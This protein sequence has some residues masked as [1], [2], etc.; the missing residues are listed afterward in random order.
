MTANKSTP[1]KIK[2]YGIPASLLA[3]GIAVGSM[4]VPINLASAQDDAPSTEGEASESSDGHHRGRHAK[5][6][7]LQE[8]LGLDREGFKAAFDEGKTLVEIAAE[9]GLS[10]DELV[11]ALVASAEERIDAAVEAGKLDPAEA[12]EKAAGVE[13]RIS[14]K[15]NADPSELRRPGHRARLA[16][17][18]L[19][20][21]GLD[22]DEVKTG[23]E[24]GKTLAAIAAEQGVSEDQLV[25]A[26]VEAAEERIDA[27]VE[28]DKIDAAEAA[29]KK[30]D[31]AENIME[32]VNAD[33]ADR[34]Q[35]GEGRPGGHHRHGG[36][37]G[38]VEDSATS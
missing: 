19:E 16:I 26:L 18:V 28:E 27:A 38:D 5:A 12:A 36:P 4:F 3:G 24:E 9:Q 21:L 11:A 33:P 23:T 1:S 29:E 13:D 31:L 8:L 34:P 35:R 20:D 32:R 30:A 2:K 14:E 22:R 10:E 7:V 37:A 25:A 17:G 15:V 6:E